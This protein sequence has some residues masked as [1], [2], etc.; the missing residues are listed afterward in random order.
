MRPSGSALGLKMLLLD[1]VCM[2]C[3]GGGITK[4]VQKVD[5]N[6]QTVI[7]G[8]SVSTCSWGVGTGKEKE[9][10]SQEIGRHRPLEY[11]DGVE[12]QCR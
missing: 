1:L 6:L 5:W 10:V 12:D 8:N 9:K 4:A 2:A 3:W 7:R 11:L